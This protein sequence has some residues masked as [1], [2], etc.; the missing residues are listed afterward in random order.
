MKIRYL[1]S[2]LVLSVLL[3]SSCSKEKCK[4]NIRNNCYVTHDVAPVCGCNGKTYGNA[5]E[6]YC[7]GIEDITSGACD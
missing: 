5:T 1:L 4:E 6:A 2:L 7:A 3:I